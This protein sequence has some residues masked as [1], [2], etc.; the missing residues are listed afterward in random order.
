MGLHSRKP[1]VNGDAGDEKPP[2][3]ASD[4]DK[5]PKLDMLDDDLIEKLD[6]NYFM[7]KVYPEIRDAA[8]ELPLIMEA[9]NQGIC[10]GSYHYAMGIHKLAAQE[11]AVYRRLRQE[12]SS[13]YADKMTE[14]A[15]KMAIAQDENLIKEKERLAVLKV[16]IKRLTNS[17][18]N[19]R[20]K[21]EAMRSV[22]STR[23]KLV[24]DDPD[25][26]N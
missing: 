5:I 11:A 7:R 18:E 12:W 25:P 4:M 8:D 9:I 14:D 20:A 24:R 21:L 3:R 17:Q 2:R 6:I 23:R 15:L 1:K 22:E 26:E 10:K 13:T 19:V 16:A